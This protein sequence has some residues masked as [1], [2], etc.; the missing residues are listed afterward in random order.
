LRA[1]TKQNDVRQASILHDESRAEQ[2]REVEEGE[3]DGGKKRKRE[4]EEV[5]GREDRDC[6]LSV[7]GDVGGRDEAELGDSV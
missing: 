6:T 1:S 3:A 4:K 5:E 2:S 7:H